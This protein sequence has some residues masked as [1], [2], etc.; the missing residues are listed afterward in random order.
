[1]P[2]PERTSIEEIT[3]AARE[4]LEAQGYAGLTMQAVADRV[5]VRAP[6]LYKRVRSRDDLVRIVAEATIQ[7]LAGHLHGVPVS[8]EPRQDLTAFAHAV[9]AFAQSRPAA[10]RL[11]VGSGP[12]AVAPG[13]DLLA[14]VLAPLLRICADLAGPDHALDAARTLTAWTT[15]F[16]TMELA[17]A[18][19]LGGDIDRAFSYGISRLGAAFTAAPGG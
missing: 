1:M 11:I 14:H 3:A 4:I 8:A 13:P 18:F 9:R 2:T 7:E 12:V 6:S 19:N 10:Y 15:G 17:G 16:I 5:G